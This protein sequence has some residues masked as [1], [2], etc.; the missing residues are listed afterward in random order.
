MGLGQA[1]LQGVAPTEWPQ[2]MGAQTLPHAIQ[3]DRSRAWPTSLEPACWRKTPSTVLS[4]LTWPRPH[5]TPAP[6][7]G[8]FRQPSHHPSTLGI[9]KSDPKLPD[10]AIFPHPPPRSKNV[11]FEDEEK[12]KV[13]L[14]GGVD[15]GSRAHLGVSEFQPLAALPVKQRLK[16]SIPVVGD[17]HCFS[18][19]S[20][21]WVLPI[22][23]P[24]FS[25]HGCLVSVGLV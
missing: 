5:H 12:S 13:R 25:K 23:C 11:I 8:P 18:G 10:D 24:A 9:V 14:Q 4:V 17:R 22:R 15:E 16:M 3:H 19:T 6:G 1:S 7:P 21:C 20:C 2:N